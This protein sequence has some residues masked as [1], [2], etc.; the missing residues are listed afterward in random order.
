MQPIKKQ[1]DE[2]IKASQLE[3]CINKHY[4]Q[5]T[6]YALMYQIQYG[7]RIDK[8]R[9]ELILKTTHEEEIHI[10]EWDLTDD[11][12]EKADFVYSE[13]IIP[14]LEAFLDGTPP[15]LLFR[16]NPFSFFGNETNNIIQQLAK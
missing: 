3:E 9:I 6:L 15:S 16:Q 10:F 2:A 5:T 4:L 8:A 14:T 12:F 1:Y 11:L 13:M 7:V